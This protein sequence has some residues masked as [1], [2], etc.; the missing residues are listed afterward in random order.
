MKTYF[1][2]NTIYHQSPTQID[3]ENGIIKDIILC[4]VGEAKG[5]DLFINDSFIDKVVQLGNENTA[6]VKARF[7]H[8]NIC[9]TA[10][11]SYL[12]RYK[13]FRK[14]DDKAIADLY[15]DK[16]S[17]KS[18]N[19]N[20][21]DYV[22]DLAESNPDMFGA[23]IAFKAGKADKK[24]ETINGVEVEKNYATIVG[25]FAAD[26][27]DDPAATNGLFKAGYTEPVEVHE[28]DF[29]FQASVFL[30]EHPEIYELLT[31]KPEILNQFL[32]NYKQY[33]ENKNTSSSEALAKEGTSFNLKDEISNLKNWITATFSKSEKEKGGHAEALEA[34]TAIEELK[35]EFESQLTSLESKY[36]ATINQLQ[37]ELNKSKAF[38]TVPDKKADPKINIQKKINTD[39]SGKVL[40]ENIPDNVKRKL[41]TK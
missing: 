20:L 16:T 35:G 40:L 24:L 33:K 22:L 18:P 4:Q 3:R 41:K 7:G 14:Q 32:I 28:D 23:S 8:P 15:L 12:G 30:D 25:L 19:G 29:A 13:N 34:S 37:T 5:H 10:L 11:G 39:D 6:G 17:I 21:Y 38:P 31:K 1:R 27:V 2:S 26:L 36:L 9:S